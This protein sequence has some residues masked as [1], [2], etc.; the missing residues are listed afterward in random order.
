MG[1]E[2]LVTRIPSLHVFART[3]V[4]IKI[5]DKSSDIDADAIFSCK[6]MSFPAYKPT[7][8]SF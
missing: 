2:K 8:L 1:N 5:N 7:I 4:K 3:C 6:F